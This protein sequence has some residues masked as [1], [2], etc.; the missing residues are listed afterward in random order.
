MSITK[1]SDKALL[2]ESQISNQIIPKYR[3]YTQVLYLV[4]HIENILIPAYY[5][6]IYDLEYFHSD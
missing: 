2:K 6:K 4:A 3:K 5:E 1:C